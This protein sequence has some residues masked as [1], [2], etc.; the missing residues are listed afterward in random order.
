MVSDNYNGLRRTEFR[1]WVFVFALWTCHPGSE[2]RQEGTLESRLSAPPLPIFHRFL[3]FLQTSFRRTNCSTMPVSLRTP[4]EGTSRWTFWK[5][6]TGTFR[7][8]NF[9]RPRAIYEARSIRGHSLSQ[10]GWP[11]G[12]TRRLLDRGRLR[13][14]RLPRLQARGP[15][16]SA[17]SATSATRCRQ[18]TD[19]DSRFPSFWFRISRESFLI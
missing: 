13:D 8:V 11:W 16:G 14:R 2:G 10:R 17:T 7:K 1:R 6:T 18:V 3:H 9:K 15:K 5:G 19:I 12:R 4:Y